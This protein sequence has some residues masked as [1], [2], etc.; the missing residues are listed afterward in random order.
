M[1]F[2]QFSSKRD[3]AKEMRKSFHLKGLRRL[4]DLGLRGHHKV[5]ALKVVAHY[6]HARKEEIKDFKEGYEARVSKT[7][8]QLQ[9]EAGQKARDFNHPFAFLDRFDKGQLTL[10]AQKRVRKAHEMTM[11]LLDRQETRELES[12]ARKA[13]RGDIDP[14]I[15]SKDFER[16]TDRRSVDERR[17]MMRSRLRSRSR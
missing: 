12:I 1:P 3:I 2:D 4:A 6:E 13:G 8:K 7:I 11:A 16:A 10:R 9:A 5:E 15:L 17:N 14:E